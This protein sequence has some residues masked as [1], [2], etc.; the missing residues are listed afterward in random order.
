[1]YQ[2]TVNWGDVAL[3]RGLVF[4]LYQKGGDSRIFQVAMLDAISAQPDGI[5]YRIR[6]GGV[7]HDLEAAL[8]ADL[9][10]SAENL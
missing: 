6:V 5:L 4:L 7:R 8:A 3:G 10:G 9:E 1:M 2:P